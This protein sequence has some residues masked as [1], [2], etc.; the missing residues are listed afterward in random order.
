MNTIFNIFILL[1]LF[2]VC[3]LVYLLFLPNSQS[4]K[5]KET[6]PQPPLRPLNTLQDGSDTFLLTVSYNPF[7]NE[8]I[9]SL[10][11]VSVG[12][13]GTAPTVA[14]YTQDNY[15]LLFNS[16]VNL[17]KPIEKLENYKFTTND[18]LLGLSLDEKTG[19]ITGSPQKLQLPYTYYV[20]ATPHDFYN[21]VG[22]KPSYVYM[23]TIEVKK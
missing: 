10:P 20:L 17:M 3:A 12:F 15:V 13:G 2:V 4:K 8:F 7:T 18:M 11:Q 22:D 19:E 9:Y 5:F 1:V 16:N 14:K 23:F 6:K 21:N